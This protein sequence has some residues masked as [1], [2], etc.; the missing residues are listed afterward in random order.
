MWLYSRRAFLSTAGLGLLSACGFS[1]VYQQGSAASG[2]ARQMAVGVVEGRYGF[3]LRER[4][5]ERYGSADAD[6]RFALT[7]D[8]TIDETELV[9]NEEAEITR[10][11][12]SGTV[13]YEV[14]NRATGELLHKDLVRTVTAYSATSATFPTTI[15]E[16]DANVRLVRALADLMVTRLSITANGWAA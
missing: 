14:R 3:E 4:L 5:I 2:L 10:Y 12:L 7:F 13:A 11:A 6:A 1:P 15:A 9:V 16:R 8:L